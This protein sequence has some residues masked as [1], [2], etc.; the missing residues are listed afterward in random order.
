MIVWWSSKGNGGWS[1][2]KASKEEVVDSMDFS[3]VGF[4]FSLILQM[5]EV[6]V[7]PT[8]RLYRYAWPR[9]R[10]GIVHEGALLVDYAW[11]NAVPP[12]GSRHIGT[13]AYFTSA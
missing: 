1:A 9:V 12:I 10:L 3:N 8:F 6:I 5:F 4:F 11:R 2:T 13:L 7:R